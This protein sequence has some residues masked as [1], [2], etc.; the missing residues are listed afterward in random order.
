MF[1]LFKKILI[2]TICNIYI[3]QKYTL[4]RTL[5]NRICSYTGNDYKCE[6]PT[7]YTFSLRKKIIYSVSTKGHIRETTLNGKIVNMVC[8]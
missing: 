8:K 3:H 4:K 6:R 5:T 1:Y 7:A 2:K